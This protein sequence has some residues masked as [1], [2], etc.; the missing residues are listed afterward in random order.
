MGR[1]VMCGYFGAACIQLASLLV[2]RSVYPAVIGVLTIHQIA[3]ERGSTPRGRA[4]NT[5]H[6]PF[7]PFAVALHWLAIGIS[8]ACYSSFCFNIRNQAA[9]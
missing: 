8:F 1:V 7:F 4:Y 6:F 5:T 2:Y 9:L 3:G